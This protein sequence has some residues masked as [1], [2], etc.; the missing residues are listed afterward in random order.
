MFIAGDILLNLF[1]LVIINEFN[2][3]YLNDDNLMDLFKTNL[4]LF[5]DTWS[6]FTKEQ[7]CLRLKET[8]MVAFF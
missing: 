5:K 6:K 7:N 1:V 3:Y 8:K 2:K 4:V